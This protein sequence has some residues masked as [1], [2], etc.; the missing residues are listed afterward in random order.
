VLVL[1]CVFPLILHFTSHRTFPKIWPQHTSAIATCCTDAALHCS[2]SQQPSDLHNNLSSVISQTLLMNL[3]I[4]LLLR[5]RIFG[6]AQ[7]PHFGE[8]STPFWG[9]Q[10]PHFEGPS[11]PILGAQHPH[12]GER[13]TPI[14]GGRSTP[15]LG[16]AVLPFWGDAVLSF[17]RDAVT[18]FWGTQ[19]SHFGGTQ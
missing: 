7:Y 2:V 5:L 19:Y 8:L 11:T 4:K 17:W 15:I 16:N 14:L 18:P 1:S 6:G 10:Y 3:A 9:A 13:S 12:F